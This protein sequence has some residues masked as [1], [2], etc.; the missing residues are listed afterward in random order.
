[1]YRKTYAE[2][3]I[4]AI[5]HN[6]NLIKN[7]IN[8][9]TKVLMAIKA[10]AYGHGAVVIGREV[11][12]LVDLY[13]VASIEEGI[14]LRD[15][16]IEIPI[17]VLGITVNNQN[18]VDALINYDLQQTVADIDDTETINNFASIAGKT[19][20]VHLKVDTGMGRI[21]CSVNMASQII[22]K[23]LKFEF[24]KIHGVFS[25]MPVSDDINNQFNDKQIKIFDNMKKDLLKNFNIPLYHISNSGAIINYRNAN[26]DMVRPGV[27]CYGYKPDP[28]CGNNLGLIPSMT[29]KSEIVF[30]KKV[31]AGTSVSYGQTY[32]TK[33][34]CNLATISVGY[35]DGYSRALSNKANVIIAGKKYPLAGRV[36]MDQIVVNLGGDYYP[37]GTEVILFGKD[38]ITAET[39]AEWSGTIPYEV[40]CGISERVPKIFTNKAE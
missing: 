14:E 15:A 24:L 33:S 16:G 28:N 37:V 36:C 22:E 12:S 7:I 17:L 10:D 32:I 21:G 27:M 8:P 34:E 26:Y 25:H 4:N 29:L 6:L 18:S 5:K 39:I 1:M 38:N 13:G 2:I 30:I 35:G 11:Q 31:S 20:N 19:G 9:G 3:D 40:T 23:S